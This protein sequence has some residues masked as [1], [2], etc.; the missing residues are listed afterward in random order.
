MKRLI[1]AP[2]LGLA[3]ASM[4]GCSDAQEPTLTDESSLGGA[5][6]DE[7]LFDAGEEVALDEV[8]VTKGTITG[9]HGDDVIQGTDDGDRIFSGPGN[10][11]V[12][13][14]GGDDLIRAGMDSDLVFGG[15]GNDTLYGEKGGDELDGRNGDD[16]IRGGNSR[17][18]LLGG[19]GD[20]TLEGQHGSD[21]LNGQD[22]TDTC[23]VNNNDTE[24]N[25]E[26]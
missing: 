14:N 17:D 5:V 16:L 2:A 10:D 21:T 6:S 9:T 26:N 1:V 20:D 22:G 18:R 3:T 8:L 25:C 19:D 4:I 23:T 7:S 13:G 12:L 24:Q 15:D 11:S